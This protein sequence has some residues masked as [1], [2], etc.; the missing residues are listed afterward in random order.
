M[1]QYVLVIRSLCL[2]QK[3]DASEAL[4]GY[5]GEVLRDPY[6]SYMVETSRK[7]RYQCERKSQ[8]T[9]LL[10]VPGSAGGR[11]QRIIVM[12]S[13]V[14]RASEVFEPI[15]CAVPVLYEVAE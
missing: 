3:S 5:L 1:Y 2:G 9:S 10:R 13:L 8:G 14:L 6:T 12:A 7:P 11:N 4:F 15:L